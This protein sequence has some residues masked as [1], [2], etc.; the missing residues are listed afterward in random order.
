[1]SK[2][3]E[4]Y[5]AST[6]I[7]WRRVAAE[8]VILDLKTSDYFSLNETAALA[9]ERLLEGASVEEAAESLSRRYKTD[10]DDAVK[11]VRALVQKLLKANALTP[12]EGAAKPPSDREL[13]AARGGKEP[14]K[15]SYVVPA[16]IAMGLLDAFSKDAVAAPPQTF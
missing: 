16:I 9:W 12:R 3:P 14:A 15:K 10:P 5:Q 8:I 13:E 4:R 2:T 6:Q 1:M 11:H 7:S